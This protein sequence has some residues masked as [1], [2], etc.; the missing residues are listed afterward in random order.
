MRA[1]AHI[2]RRLLP[3][4]QHAL[5]RVYRNVEAQ[6]EPPHRQAPP[7]V[8]KVVT[9]TWYDDGALG[10]PYGSV[11]PEAHTTLYLHGFQYLPH[12]AVFVLPTAYSEAERALRVQAVAR[13]LAAQGIGTNLRHAT[14]AIST[15]LP[16]SPPKTARA[17]HR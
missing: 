11:P 16:P 12:Q 10:A 8:S 14:P 1:A 3:R 17:H 2:T 7:Q 5:H 6:P 13:Q 4:Y 15:A 9:L